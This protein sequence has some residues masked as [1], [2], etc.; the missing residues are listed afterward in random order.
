MLRASTG[1]VAQIASVAMTRFDFSARDKGRILLHL[2]Q[3]V[4]HS[5]WPAVSNNEFRKCFETAPNKPSTASEIVESL[6][7]SNEI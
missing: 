2:E 5:S 4:L 3:I 6:S 7:N 1:R